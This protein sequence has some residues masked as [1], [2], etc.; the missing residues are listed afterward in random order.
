MPLLPKHWFWDLVLHKLPDPS[1]LIDSIA[2]ETILNTTG[3]MF[4]TKLYDALSDTQQE[5]ICRPERLEF[6]HPVPIMMTRKEY[7]TL[8]KNDTLYGLH[9]THS[10]WRDDELL[11]NIQRRRLARNPIVRPFME[12]WAKYKQRH[13]KL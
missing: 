13:H 5:S 8:K 1:I 4:L 6:H 2:H 11:K 12:L 3:P 9:H 7:R 10:S